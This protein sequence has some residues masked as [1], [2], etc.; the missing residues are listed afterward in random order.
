M[1]TPEATVP[2]TR[3]RRS[4]SAS[5]PDQ[6]GRQLRADGRQADTAEHGKEH[7]ELRRQGGAE[8]HHGGHEVAGVAA[9]GPH[10]G[11]LLLGQAQAPEDVAGCVAVVQEPGEERQR[12]IATLF[13]GKEH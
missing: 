10:M 6:R 13:A 1:R 8:K 2:T 12:R 11:D 5:F 9:V 7:G 4:G 3:P